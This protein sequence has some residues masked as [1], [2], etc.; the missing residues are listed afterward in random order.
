MKRKKIIL[1]SQTCSKK[2]EKIETQHAQTV[3]P[4]IATEIAIENSKPTITIW[5]HGTR[6]LP[7]PILHAYVYSKPGL[8]PITILDKNYYLRQSA[9]AI[10]EAN[11][12]RYPAEHFY[13]FGWSGKLN[14]AA[15]KIASEQLHHELIDLLAHYE[16]KYTVKPTIRIITHS[17]GGNIALHLA[18]MKHPENALEIE[19]LILLACPVQ[20]RTM[21]HIEDPMFKKTYALYSSLDM[22]QILAPQFLYRIERKK[23]KNKKMGIKMPLFSSKLFPPHPKLAQ[24]KVK[25][26]GTAI[27]HTTFSNA[28]FTRMLPTIIDEIDSWQLAEQQYP[29]DKPDTRRLISIYT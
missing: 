15:R 16:K 24:L 11:P 21:H 25:L 9:D 13:S 28:S 10:I 22:L 6:L 18:E 20:E 5:I 8:H 17:H 2:T 1:R 4:T 26:N 23:Y 14:A 29:F 7:S 27:F 3:Q 12:E 19:E